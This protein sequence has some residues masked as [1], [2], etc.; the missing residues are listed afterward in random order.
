M[1]SKQAICL[2]NVKAH[3]LPKEE[4]CDYASH[5]LSLEK[6]KT[7]DIPQHSCIDCDT[8]EV[9]RNMLIMLRS[10]SPSKAVVNG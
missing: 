8:P 5:L 4:W 2:D 6:E 9:D 10:L 7:C 1:T 3:V